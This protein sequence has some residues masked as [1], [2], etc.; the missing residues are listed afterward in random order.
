MFSLFEG[1]L[2]SFWLGFV[3]DMLRFSGKMAA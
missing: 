2:L 3:D 1:A